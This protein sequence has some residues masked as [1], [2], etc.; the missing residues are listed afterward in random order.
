MTGNILTSCMTVR[1]SRRILL[2]VV[3][4][5][6]HLPRALLQ[7]EAIWSRIM[8]NFERS[9]SRHKRNRLQPI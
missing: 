8:G 1:F 2:D 7:T 6:S 3:S 5:K 4:Y 9:I